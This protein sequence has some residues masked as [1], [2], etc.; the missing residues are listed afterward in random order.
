MVESPAN[1]WVLSG[2][3]SSRLR[4]SGVVR[5]MLGGLVRWRALRSDGV[6]PVRVSTVTASPISAIGSTRLRCTSIASA[7]SGET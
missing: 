1:R 3:L 4:D 7:L 2:W 5:R 6:S